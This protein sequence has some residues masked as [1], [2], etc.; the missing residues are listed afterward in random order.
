MNDACFTMENLHQSSG[1]YV[2]RGSG[3]GCHPFSQPA[4]NPAQSYN[5]GQG[6]D[7]TDYPAT[8]LAQG[9]PALLPGF[10]GRI[11]GGQVF[12]G[13]TTA[14]PVQFHIAPASSFATTADPNYF[15]SLQAVSFDWCKAARPGDT[16]EVL[17]MRNTSNNLP[18]DVPV[19]M[20]RTKVPLP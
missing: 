18:I 6:S 8:I 17:G 4:T 1:F 10:I 20:C 7:S 13:N 19:F 14:S 9:L 3:P 11:P 12:P 5:H 2:R 16:A 15:P